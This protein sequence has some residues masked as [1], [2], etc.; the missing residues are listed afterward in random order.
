ME[1][2]QARACVTNRRSGGA[3][4]ELRLWEAIRQRPDSP[5]RLD[6]KSVFEIPILPRAVDDALV[7][8]VTIVFEPG[9]RDE[10]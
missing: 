3:L 6:L 8:R 9:C 7:R 2:K 10:N 1:A 4:R 5:G